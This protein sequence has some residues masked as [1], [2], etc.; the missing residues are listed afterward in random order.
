MLPHI[1]PELHSQVNNYQYFMRQG[2]QINITAGGELC[3]FHIEILYSRQRW[4]FVSFTGRSVY[5]K[6]LL[7]HAPDSTERLFI[8]YCKQW[9]WQLFFWT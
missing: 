2:Q 6:H 5:W 4:W 9:F 8:I 7:I 3:L 1:K